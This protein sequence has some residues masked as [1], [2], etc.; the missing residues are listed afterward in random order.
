[1]V[2]RNTDN[3]LYYVLFCAFTIGLF[4][5]LVQYTDIVKRS[6]YFPTYFR[7]WAISSTINKYKISHR[8]TK[9]HHPETDNS[10]NPVTPQNSRRARLEKKTTLAAEA[11]ANEAGCQARR[12]GSSRSWLSYASPTTTSPSACPTTSSARKTTTINSSNSWPCR[13]NRP[14]QTRPL[15]RRPHHRHP[16]RR[17]RCS[18]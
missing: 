4:H 16:R 10:I 1:M 5:Y 8:F 17:R 7:T 15:P 18:S 9:T 2:Y 11:A 3:T 6:F 13:P 12:S 14:P